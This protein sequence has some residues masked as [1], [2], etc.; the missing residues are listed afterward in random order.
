M[1]KLWYVLALLLSTTLQA[2]TVVLDELPEKM[3]LPCEREIM[4]KKLTPAIIPMIPWRG[5]NLMFPFE[6]D[7]D[8]TVY[9]LS[10]GDVWT[11]DKALKGSNIVTLTFKEFDKNRNWGTVQDFTIAT[12]GYVFSFALHAVQDPSKHCTNIR[13]TLSEAEK[14]RLVEERKQ[15][16]RKVIEQEYAEQFSK[17]DDNAEEKALLMMAGLAQSKPERTRI[18]EE[19]TLKLP[20][21]DELV[22]YV[23]NSKTYGT[24]T[25]LSFDIENH[26]AEKPV[27]IE[28]LSLK[29]EGQHREIKGASTLP[30][31]INTDSEAEVTFVTRER[32]PETGLALLLKTKA[33]DIE[34]VW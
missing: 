2:Q 1:N 31:K 14:K 21:G 22:V 10:G 25:T 29:K 13:L 4:V 9:S 12:Q 27:Y 19:G 15:N 7:E 11:F 23:A 32:L 3:I 18:K 34:V 26:G 28:G 33:G 17:L 8:V 6:L 30:K 16:Y 5:V 20:N 24:F